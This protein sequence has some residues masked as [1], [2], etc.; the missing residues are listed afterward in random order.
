LISE[1]G[2][3]LYKYFF[4]SICIAQDNHHCTGPDNHHCT[5]PNI[6]TALFIVSSLTRFHDSTYSD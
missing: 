3:P 2:A 6:S 1:Y 4:I 5:G